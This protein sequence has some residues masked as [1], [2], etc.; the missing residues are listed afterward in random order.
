MI[1]HFHHKVKDRCQGYSRDQP[2]SKLKYTLELNKEG[3]LA[4][5]YDDISEVQDCESL[6][7]FLNDYKNHH[8]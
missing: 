3:H 5:H 4:L 2:L 7:S 8:D 6:P 1:D